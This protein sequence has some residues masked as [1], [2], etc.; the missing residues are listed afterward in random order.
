MTCWLC[1]RLDR[2]GTTRS[3][4][5][6]SQLYGSPSL[7][8]AKVRKT[9]LSLLLNDPVFAVIFVNDSAVMNQKDGQWTMTGSV[10]NILVLPLH[11]LD[12][13]N[14]LHLI[15][16]LRAHVMIGVSS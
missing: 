5:E 10:K 1:A 8:K 11:T 2:I 13:T 12:T 15:W 9:H 16:T 4:K 3:C 6:P 14:I 7:G